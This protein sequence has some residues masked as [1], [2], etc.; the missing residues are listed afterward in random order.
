MSENPFVR[1]LEDDDQILALLST[2]RSWSAYALCDLEA[3]HRQ[4]A[5]YIG[6][7]RNGRVTALVLAY[8]PPS[9]TSLQPC[10]DPGDVSM[11]LSQA[12]RLPV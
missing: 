10:G 11:I 2:Q 1:E 5:R 3:P 9:F 4:Y 7:V 8:C 12:P 6:A